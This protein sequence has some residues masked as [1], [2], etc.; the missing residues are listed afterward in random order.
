MKKIST[1]R[2]VFYLLLSLPIWLWLAWFFTPKRKLVAAIVDKTV[3]TS[4]AQE[5]SS[6]T[7][8]LRHHRYSKTKSKLYSIGDYFG[9]FPQDKQLYKI[10]G[11]ERFSNE[12]LEQLSQDSDLTYYTDTYGIYKQEWFEGKNQSERSGILYGGMSEQDVFFLRTMKKNKKLI[13]LEFNAINSPTSTTIRNRFELEFGMHWTGWIGRYFT[14]LDSTNTELP[15]WLVRNYVKQQGRWS[16]KKSGIAFV[17]DTD[18]IVVLESGTHLTEE[19]PELV[20]SQLGREYYGLPARSPYSY[21][22]DILLFNPRLNQSVADY[23][24]K[25]NS[26]GKSELTRY[27]IPTR[28]PAILRHKGADYEFYYFAGDYSDNPVK[29]YSASFKWIDKVV[30]LF[31]HSATLSDRNE[32]FWKVYQPMMA[33]ILDDYH[34]QVATRT[35]TTD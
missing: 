30:P 17:K 2:L 28:F 13:M 12:Q 11:L 5:H 16:F 20:A 27:G 35:P 10:K 33:R 14:S 19:I 24:I 9:F 26:K 3:L 32:F 23:E 22:F 29:L 6:L 4:D 25:P 7:W 31:M 21:W 18:Q 15:R 8:I 1:V 34:Q